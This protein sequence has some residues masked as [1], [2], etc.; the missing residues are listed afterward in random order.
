MMNKWI[1][2]EIAVNVYQGALMIY[3]LRKVLLTQVKHYY[4]DVVFVL[5]IALT[6]SSYLFLTIPFIDT[7]ACSVSVAP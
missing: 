4:Y 6:L 5:L 3:F 7:V 1:F 2:F